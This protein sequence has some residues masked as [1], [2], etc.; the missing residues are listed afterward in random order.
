MSE[1]L[2]GPD[3]P[4]ARVGIRT[5]GHVGTLRQLD[6]ACGVMQIMALPPAIHCTTLSCASPTSEAHP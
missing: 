6:C 1:R 5:R 4:M 2:S 3:G